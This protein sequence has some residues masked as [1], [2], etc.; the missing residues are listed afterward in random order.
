LNSSFDIELFCGTEGVNNGYQLH[1]QFYFCVVVAGTTLLFATMG[2]II[3][4]KGENKFRVEGM[5]Y[6]G[7]QWLYSSLLQEEPILSYWQP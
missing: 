4:Q 6:I 3:T 5:M 1:F 2:E 7:L